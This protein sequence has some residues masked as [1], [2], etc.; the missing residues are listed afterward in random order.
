MIDWTEARVDQLKQLADDGL[1]A[2]QIADGM[3]IR[4]LSRNAVIGKLRRLGVMLVA[5]R[6]AQP[7]P[8]KA[9]RRARFQK[10]KHKFTEIRPGRKTSYGGEILIVDMQPIDLPP[11]QS[12]FACTI[13]Q[14]GA[15][16]CRWPMGTPSV[17]MLYCGRPSE[18]GVSYCLGHARIAY[19][20]ARRRE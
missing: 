13:M 9:E 8:K 6:P 2:G 12:R 10:P 18:P 19:Q 15:S 1:T 4:G 11:E 17:H 14:L 7:R 20:P 16:S 5:R 3:D